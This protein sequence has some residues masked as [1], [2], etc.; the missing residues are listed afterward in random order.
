MSE[1][2]SGGGDRQPFTAGRLGLGR[3]GRGDDPGR[4]PA[5]GFWSSATPGCPAGR[6]SST[7]HPRRCSGATTGNRSSRSRR[8][9]G[10]RSSCA[11][12]P[13]GSR[14]GWR[15]RPWLSSPV[16]TGSG[17][18]CGRPRHARRARGEGTGP[19]SGRPTR[20][21][22][23]QTQPCRF[24]MN[25]SSVSRVVKRRRNG[26]LSQTLR[27]V[28]LYVSVNSLPAERLEVLGELLGGERF[29]RRR[30]RRSVGGGR[31]R[32]P[33]FPARGRPGRR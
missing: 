3:P 29:A 21:T 9:D 14:R 16:G 33:G 15:S 23:R 19:E 5:P 28:W 10:T 6:R 24:R 11:T 17:C 32:R 20:R 30:P 18:S 4:D 13:P 1:T 7:G 27:S 31:G 25:H 22:R 8:P 2:R 12:S 26:Q